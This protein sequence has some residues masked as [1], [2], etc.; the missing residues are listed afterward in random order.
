MSAACFLHVRGRGRGAH[1]HTPGLVPRFQHR[2]QVFTKD[3][4]ARKKA[5]LCGSATAG[6]T[7]VSGGKGT[8]WVCCANR[9]QQSMGVD[10]SRAASRSGRLDVCVCV[11]GFA[12]AA[13]LA[14][15][16]VALGDGGPL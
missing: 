3:G 14:C 8:D 1:M 12:G 11:G 4:V 13:G 5:G 10:T 15:N 2:S 6:D 7:A 16:S 9:G